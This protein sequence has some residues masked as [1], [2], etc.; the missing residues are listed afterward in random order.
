ML[1]KRYRRCKGC[2][3]A[4]RFLPVR[5]DFFLRISLIHTERSYLTVVRN[6][7]AGIPTLFKEVLS[8][9]E[10]AASALTSDIL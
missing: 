8:Q 9:E 10:L 5:F 1:K 2:F 6:A 7:F 3:L 4:E